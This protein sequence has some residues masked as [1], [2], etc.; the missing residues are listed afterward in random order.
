[1]QKKYALLVFLFQAYLQ[2][3]YVFFVNLYKNIPKSRYL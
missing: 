1:M 2:I 3:I